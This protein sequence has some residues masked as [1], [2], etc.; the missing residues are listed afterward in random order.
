MF[1]GYNIMRMIA[2]ELALSGLVH[3]K[4]HSLIN[5]F[6]DLLDP[7][8]GSTIREIDRE[9]NRAVFCIFPD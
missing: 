1:F 3:L 9:D 6:K 2:V 4:P 8:L 5:A 7:S